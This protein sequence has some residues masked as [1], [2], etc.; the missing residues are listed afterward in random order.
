VGEGL[1]LWR[2]DLFSPYAGAMRGELVAAIDR[3]LVQLIVVRLRRNWP[4]LELVPASW[5]FPIVAPAARQLRRSVYRGAVTVAVTTGA[6]IMVIS[7]GT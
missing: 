2:A 3:R 7:L 5:I 4:P 1:Q 6:L